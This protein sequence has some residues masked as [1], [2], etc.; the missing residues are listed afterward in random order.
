M[1]LTCR[2]CGQSTPAT[3]FYKAKGT[4]TGRE[5]QCKECAKKRR[6]AY[7][8]LWTEGNLPDYPRCEACGD[9]VHH[10][11][12]HYCRKDE[13]Q[14]EMRRAQWRKKNHQRSERKRREREAYLATNPLPHCKHCGKQLTRHNATYCSAPAC[15]K[16]QSRSP[17]AVA[18]RKQWFDENDELRREYNRKNKAKR[19]ALRKS[20]RTDDVTWHGIMERDHW[21]CQLC[22]KPIDPDL[23]APDPKSAT[24]DHIV[25]LV[26]GGDHTWANLQASH[27]GCNARKS[28]RGEPQQLALI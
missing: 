24:W 23:K 21:T 26:E 27:Y 7:K 8:K 20:C 16:A 9:K 17:E 4:R 28:N 2:T 13:C 6:G 15:R 1:N 14:R 12:A 5:S 10:R 3:E 19:R 18:K 22:G 11:G 25:P